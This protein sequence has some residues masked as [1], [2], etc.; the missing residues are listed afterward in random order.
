MTYLDGWKGETPIAN[1]QSHIANWSRFKQQMKVWPW[2]SITTYITRFVLLIGG[3]I[4]A[5]RYVGRHGMT[6]DQGIIYLLVVLVPFV[7]VWL[8]VERAVWNHELREQGISSDGEVWGTD[9]FP[10]K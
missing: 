7:F 9:Q 3:V 4:F 2:L 1:A 6:K 8:F 5:V 10:P